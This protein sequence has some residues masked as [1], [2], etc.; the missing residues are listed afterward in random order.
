MRD[1][2]ESISP[3]DDNVK[4]RAAATNEKTAIDE[5]NNVADEDGEDLDEDEG[6]ED[7]EEVEEFATP[8]HPRHWRTASNMGIGTLSR[9]SSSTWL[10]RM[11]VLSV[12]TGQNPYG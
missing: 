8:H 11:Y 9:Q 3:S 1:G 12:S 6:D 7:G 5:R 4:P 10:T 2:S